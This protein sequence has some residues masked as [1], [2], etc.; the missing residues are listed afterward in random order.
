[1]YLPVLIILTGLPQI[2]YWKKDLMDS[3]L[4]EELIVIPGNRHRRATPFGYDNKIRGK[5]SGLPSYSEIEADV[6]AVNTYFASNSSNVVN[7]STPEGGEKHQVPL[8]TKEVKNIV[9]CPTCKGGNWPYLPH[10]QR[11]QG[12]WLSCGHLKGVKSINFP[13]PKAIEQHC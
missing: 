4:H 9:N 1:M 5:V 3:T 7:F 11:R 8:H 10:M 6:V 13:T 2:R 12:A